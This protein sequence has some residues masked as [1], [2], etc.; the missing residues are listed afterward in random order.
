MVNP[1]KPATRAGLCGPMTGVKVLDLGTMFAGPF[2]A[3]LLGDF[4]AEVIKVE[5]PKTGDPVRNIVVVNGVSGAWSILNRNKRCVSLDVR[6]EKGKALL[7]R[8][9]AW[10]DIVVEN[11]RPGT[12]EGWGLGYPEMKAVNPRLI[13]IR[14]SGYGQTGPHA[15]KA[16][17]GTP[18]TAFSGFT[19]LTG[20]PDRPPVSPPFALV[21]YLTGINGAMAAVMALYYLEKHQAPE[22]QEVDI[23]L[24]ESV[25][26]LLETI[27]AEYGMTGKVRE[28]IGH[29]ML[30][31]APCGAFECQDGKWVVI[32]T[33]T[34]RT[35][36]RL[37][38][39]MG[40]PEWMK[41]PRYNT[42]PSR[43]KN[44]EELLAMT[45]AWTR[46]HPAA[47][48]LKILD[49]EGVP[50]CPINSM[51]DIFEDPHY[52]ARENLVQV[53]HP[54]LG[55]MTMPGIVPK[56]SQTPGAIRSAGPV[57][58]GEHNGE[59][60]RDLLG[61]KDEELRGLEAEGVI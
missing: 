11:F 52:Q 51:A 23:A 49:K 46:Q 21:D 4:G 28:R 42:N 40:H 18:A 2:A 54:V 48:L 57:K 20:Y 14:I 44:R 15:Y 29:T 3:A 19:Y 25:F 58:I 12:L 6:K 35:F 38:E 32:V 10:A 17:F 27:V 47:E 34:D 24:Y 1:P 13:M 7:K 9:V 60:Y 45:Q 31:S 37:A 5:L 30:E 26:R 16:G 41:D 36:T 43:V 61:V 22:G 56:F 53:E 59:V 50:V 8:L 39:A 33:S 55:K